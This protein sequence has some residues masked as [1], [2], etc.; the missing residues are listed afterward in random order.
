MDK[1]TIYFLRSVW[2]LLLMVAAGCAIQN[3]PTGGPEDKTPPKVRKAKPENQMLYFDKKSITLGFDSYLGSVVFGKQ[4]FISPLPKTPPKILVYDRRLIIQLQDSLAPNTTYVIAVSDVE[5]YFSKLKMDKPYIYAFSTGDFLDSL[6]VKGNVLSAETGKGEG[7]MTVLLYDETRVKNN[8]ILGI[9]PNYIAKTDASGNF[10]FTN[11]RRTRY[12]LYAVKDADNSNSYNLPDER[13]AMDSTAWVSFADTSKTALKYLTSFK[14]D[15]RPPFV[16]GYEWVGKN[17]L[18]IE[19][20]ETLLMDTLTVTISDTLGQQSSKA[21]TAILLKGEKKTVFLLSHRAVNQVSNVKLR[22]MSDSL[23]NHADTVVRVYPKTPSFVKTYPLLKAPY[24]DYATKKL[25]VLFP[26]YP[27][28][29]LLKSVQMVDSTGKKIRFTPK[30]NANL[31]QIAIDTLL[32]DGRSLK[33]QITQKWMGKDSVFSWALRYPDPKLFGTLEG[34][35]ITD[36][37]DGKIVWMLSTGGGK[38][39]NEATVI[40]GKERAFDLKYLTPGN[41]TAKVIFDTDGNGCWTPGSLAKNTMPE[42]VVVLPEPINIRANWDLTKF[43]IKTQGK[44]GDGGGKKGA[45]K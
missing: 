1:Y 36:G 32:P 38:G 3:Q 5:D 24:W 13:V 14:Q 39:G 33:L 37:Y 17:S 7:E 28:D 29:T 15:E 34:K 12:K 2:V 26:D 11:L 22:F 40:L 45:G 6:E 42:K 4:L 20:S 35:V 16:R 41:Y 27:S 30:L 31:L 19:V 18:Q 43:E 23:G 25:Q 10:A 44:A 9:Q 21:D 8:E